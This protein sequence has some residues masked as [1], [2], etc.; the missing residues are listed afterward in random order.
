MSA[1]PQISALTSDAAPK[2]G[3]V[4]FIESWPR[5]A[6]AGFLG[7]R[8]TV[9]TAQ[10]ALLY[11]TLPLDLIEALTYGREWQLG[12]DKL[13]PLPWWLVEIM[14][15]VFGA[16]AAYY[17]LA[18]AAV[19]VA[20]VAVFATARPLVGAAG[21]LVAVLIIDGMHYF[22]YTAV[23]FNHD[24]IQLPFWAGAGYALHAALKRGKVIHWLLLG[25]AF[26]GALWAKYFVVVLAVPY[27]LFIVFDRD[28]RRAL[29]TP[30]P[31]LALG[32]ALLI[33]L[34]HVIWLFRTSR[35]AG[36]RL[37]RSRLASAR[38]RRR[39]DVLPDPDVPDCRR[40]GM[41]AVKIG[42]HAAYLT[43]AFGR[44]IRPQDRDAPRLRPCPRHDRADRD[45]RAGHHRDVGLSAVAV[46]RFVDRLG[47]ARR[48]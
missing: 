23:K 21:A 8:F 18:Q 22:Q 32:V 16:D 41:A 42:R 39:A 34:P 27:A 4:G 40:A 24:V 10:P 2:A 13:P 36:A 9:W 31:W 30:G 5:A 29:R 1:T 47:G 7:G 37:V 43:R 26:G 17:A 11:A 12:Y 45:E 20:F 15:R 6:F 28:G 38:F 44:C 48:H 33:A 14:H 19:I 46:P 25:L 35:R 3:F